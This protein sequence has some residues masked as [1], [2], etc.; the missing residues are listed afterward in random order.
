MDKNFFFNFKELFLPF[1]KILLYVISTGNNHFYM[2]MLENWWKTTDSARCLLNRCRS[3]SV[4][5][6]DLVTVRAL[7]KQTNNAA[8][9]VVCGRSP[10]LLL[11]HL[12]AFIVSCSSYFL[13]GWNLNHFNLSDRAICLI[14]KKTWKVFWIAT[15]T[16][17]SFLMIRAINFSPC[18][19]VSS[20]CY[21]VVKE[22]GRFL[23]NVASLFYNLFRKMICCYKG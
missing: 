5:V 19:S 23:V 21:T 22:E 16:S 8:Q 9:D 12:F 3:S 18:G 20:G 14:I 10:L 11:P 13:P 1:T 2:P 17:G 7:Q 6:L 4:C 15:K